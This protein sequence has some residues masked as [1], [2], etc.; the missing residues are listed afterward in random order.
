[1]LE[2]AVAVAVDVLR[3][4]EIA[5]GPVVRVRTGDGPVAVNVIDHAVAVGVGV[6]V[7]HDP[8]NARFPRF[9]GSQG[10]VV[11][12]PGHRV[13]DDPGD[14]AVPARGIV[15]L[16]PVDPLDLVPVE[17]HSLEQDGNGHL[18][19][20]R[21]EIRS[22]V[23]RL[24]LGIELVAVR[25]GG[26][27]REIPPVVHPDRRAGRFQRGEVDLADEP[28]EEGEDLAEFVV[29]RGVGRRARVDRPVAEPD[30]QGHVVDPGLSRIAEPVPVQVVEDGPL[31]G[32]EPPG[33]EDV[34][35]RDRRRPSLG[36][37]R[38]ERGRVVKHG[39]DG[40]EER[41]DVV[42]VGVAI[43]EDEL[44]RPGG[45]VGDRELPRHGIRRLGVDQLVHVV[46]VGD[47]DPGVRYGVPVGEHRKVRRPMGVVRDDPACDGA[48][49]LVVDRVVDGEE[50]ND[51]INDRV[52]C[53]GERLIGG[54][55]RP[56]GGDVVGV[57]EPDEDVREEEPGLVEDGRLVRVDPRVD[58]R[59]PL[60]R[61]R[62]DPVVRGHRGEG[63]PGFRTSPGRGT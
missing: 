33:D 56:P 19:Q 39:H 22:A 26:V 10:R 12:G 7:H 53:G 63:R 23:I 16:P 11:L 32:S 61:R 28:F 25:A 41:D 14:P 30:V 35:Q 13:E 27:P 36:G 29:P 52:V 8:G 24:G 45:D 49:L 38:R 42:H 3:T 50:R 59:R 6:Q 1:M 17:D 54:F 60:E 9:S 34:V 18:G 47:A 4:G 55:Q 37:S 46:Q 2:H 62:L 21:P 5:E 43:P 31:P 40:R 20:L 57:D 44:V 15:G 51:S 58:P 48:V